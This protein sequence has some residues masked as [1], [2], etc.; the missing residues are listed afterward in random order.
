[1]PDAS[2]PIVCP[3]TELTDDTVRDFEAAVGPHVEATGPGIVIDLERV[4]FISSAGLGCLVKI[5]MRL[6]QRG[7][8]IAL[9][10][11]APEVER[12]LRLIGL[13]TKLPMFPTVKAAANHLAG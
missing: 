1:M 6:D 9:A 11:P 10:R 7:R 12:S 4:A 3:P 13:D 2:I 8:R 5:G